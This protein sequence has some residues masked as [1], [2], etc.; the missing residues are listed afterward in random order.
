MFNLYLLDLWGSRHF[1]FFE[2]NCITGLDDE[3]KAI[4][5][6]AEHIVAGAFIGE[7]E[8]RDDA[9]LFNDLDLPR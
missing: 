3:K 6:L 8:V 9:V 5:F 1:D 4:E 7:N 2:G